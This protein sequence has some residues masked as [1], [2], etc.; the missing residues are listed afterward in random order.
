MKMEQCS[1][2]SAYQIRRREITQKKAHNIQN[3]AKVYNEGKDE[4][5]QRVILS[6]LLLP[7]LLCFQIT[8]TTLFKRLLKSGVT[9]HHL[10]VSSGL[11]RKLRTAPCVQFWTLAFDFRLN[12]DGLYMPIVFRSSSDF[13]TLC[14]WT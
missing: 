2:T 13:I 7:S 12:W 4:L 1:E 14:F 5:L 6:M 3:T 10:F 11:I 8:S 9:Q